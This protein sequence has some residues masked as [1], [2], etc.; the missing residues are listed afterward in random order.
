MSGFSKSLY[1][2]GGFTSRPDQFNCSRIF[3]C[4]WLGLVLLLLF[5][6]Q[7]EFLHDTS[8]LLN[9]MTGLS[10]GL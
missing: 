4:D 7:S 1:F 6:V 10:L 5:D 8:G 9:D 3:I 2:A